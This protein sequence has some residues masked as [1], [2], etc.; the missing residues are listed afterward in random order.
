MGLLS[1]GSLDTRSWQGLGDG[2]MRVRIYSRGWNGGP[3]LD[4]MGV[5]Y[6]EYSDDGDTPTYYLETSQRVVYINQDAVLSVVLDYE[7]GDDDAGTLD[8]VDTT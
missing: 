8:N 1:V 2:A 6:V 4:F 3:Y 7:E 5:D